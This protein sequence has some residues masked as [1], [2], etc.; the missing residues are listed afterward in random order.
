MASSLGSL[1]V[2]LGL[3]AAQYVSGLSRSQYEAKKFVDNFER[4]AKRMAGTA[5][6]LGATVLGAIAAMDR[7]ADTIAIY[8]GLSEQI[9]TTAVN[10]AGLRT[11]ADVSGVALD[12]VAAASVRLTASL[13]KQNDASSEVGTA[14]AAINIPFED[15]IRLDPVSQLERVAAELSKFEDGA[16]KTAVAVALFGRAGAELIPFLNDLADEGGRN[17][18]LT[19]DQITA[20]DEYTKTMARLKSELAQNAQVLIAEMVPGFQAVLEEIQNS[21]VAASLLETGIAAVRI[22]FEAI[23]ILGANVAYV[24]TAVGREIGAIAAQITALATLDLKG[25]RAISKAVREDAERA[26]LELD[27]FERRVMRLDKPEA[28]DNWDLQGSGRPTLNVGGLGGGR[29]GGASKQVS[30]AQ[31]Y[32]ESLQ[33]Q[34]RAARDL[35]AEVTALEEIE[36]GRLGKVNAAQRD[37]ILQAARAVDVIKQQQEEQKRLEG[38]EKTLIEQKKALQSEAAAIFEATRT[39]TEQLAAELARL[40]YLLD[41][42]YLSW[43]TYARAVMKAQETADRAAENF[44]QKTTEMDEF[45]KNAAQNI[46]RYLGDNL[47]NI[48]TGNFQSIGQEFSNMILRMVAEAQAAQIARYLFGDLVKGGE[49]GGVL[50]GVMKSIGSIFGGGKAGGGPV[51]PGMMYRVAENRPEMLDVNGEQFLLMGK[52]RGHIDPNPRMGGGRSV[53]VTNHFIVQGTPGRQTQQQIAAAT[54]VAVSRA[55]RRLN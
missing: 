6:A 23:V 21:T 12:T 3:D 39:P 28:K 42:G 1:V 33:K 54:G 5:A 20:A 8:K 51:Y 7:A 53:N 41:E 44:K 37:Q 40:Q 17:A 24:F 45:A 26:R 48:M 18:K 38:I 30:E 55:T 14:L 19:E 27:A 4:D 29:G 2:S 43:D 36:S 34:G 9:G 11:A 32:L 10:V 50:G 16:G 13:S 15:F 46:Q 49:G 22:A 31:R 47:Y 35:S 25:F 52:Q